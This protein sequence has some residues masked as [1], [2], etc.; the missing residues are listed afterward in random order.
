MI[1]LVMILAVE[2]AIAAPGPSARPSPTATPDLSSFDLPSL[3]VCDGTDGLS[4]LDLKEGEPKVLWAGSEVRD[5][6]PQGDGSFLVTGG[7]AGLACLRRDPKEGWKAAWTWEQ[8]NLP[9]LVNAVAVEWEWK[10]QPSLILASDC[11]LNRLVLGEARTQAPKIR[12]EFRLPAPPQRVSVCPDSGNFLVTLK[13]RGAGMGEPPQVAEVFFREDRVGWYLDSKNGITRTQ[14][15]VRTPDGHTLVVAGKRATLYCFDIAKNLLWQKPLAAT[16]DAHHV[17]SLA[18]RGGKTFL[19]VNARPMSSSPA[20]GRPASRP[21]KPSGL[22]WVDPQEGR[23]LAFRSR[24]R[25]GPAPLA[26]VT[27][28][29]A[30]NRPK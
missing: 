27:E 21:R 7:P 8:M 12:W 9:C 15:A 2:T 23:I 11:T 19:L 26:V 28:D 22:Y 4:R 1:L 18:K 25:E 13:A 29:S 17:L 30:F 5:A 16:P 14:D 24:I 10:G 3:L 6:Q 20:P